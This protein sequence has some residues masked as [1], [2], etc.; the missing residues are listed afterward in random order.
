LR[1][2]GK[3][4]G[5]ADLTA[6]AWPAARL[7]EVL[8][9]LARRSGLAP[10]L[11]E[12]MSPPAGLAGHDDETLGHWLRMAAGHL[13]MEAER[14]EICYSEVEPLLQQT[15]PAL[16]QLP[17]D[18]EPCLLVLL[19]GG[20]RRLYLLGPDLA[21][22]RLRRTLVCAAL[23]RDLE[24]PLAK[25]VDRL[26]IEAGVPA[27]RQA[28][29]W[30]AMLHERLGPRR[31]AICWFI[32][33]PAGAGFWHQARQVRLPRYLVAFVGGHTVQYLLWLLAWWVVGQGALQGRLDHSWLLAWALL[34]VTLA[35]FRLLASWSQ[36]LLAI[37][38]GSLL[39][40]CLLA[41]A[42]RLEPEEIRHQGAGQFLGRVLE[43]EAVGALALSGGLV[44]GM[45]GIEILIA[46]AVLGAGVGGG[47]H[48][49]LLLTWVAVALLLGWHY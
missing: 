20:R 47:T 26:L 38:A 10:R 17:G 7:G 21:V 14:V 43:A 8:E 19:G 2:V 32:R 23:R 3:S 36:G 29:A 5:T 35:P 44:G 25:E 22:Q 45:A 13:G 40:Q 11:A 41:G 15:G 42:L 34:L 24:A 4:N 31:L 6:L 16:L 12:P 30:E 49:L 27:P 18:G 1:L 9:A 28:R 46:A 48:A 39:K 33:L 37:G